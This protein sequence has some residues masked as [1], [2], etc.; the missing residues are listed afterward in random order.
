MKNL[1]APIFILFLMASAFAPAK[2]GSLYTSP[3]AAYSVVFPGTFTVEKSEGESYITTK[4]MGEAD[5]INYMTSSTIHETDLSS[6]SNLEQVS[7]DAFSNQIAGNVIATSTW[8]SKNLVG[9]K[10]NI[11]S[12]ANNMEMEYIV[13]IDGNIQYQFIVFTNIS[14]YN[15]KAAKTFFKSIS[16][17]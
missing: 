16:F 5:G 17:N 6:S 3:D 8:K 12:E 10:A 7:L 15:T 14:A 11:I 13:A 9:L 1:I 4:V 2:K